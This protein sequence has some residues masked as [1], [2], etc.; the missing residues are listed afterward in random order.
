M[1]RVSLWWCVVSV[2]YKVR[3]KGQ[4]RRFSLTSLT[5][6]TQTLYTLYA[7]HEPTISLTLTRTRVAVCRVEQVPV[8]LGM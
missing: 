6:L 3:V 8:L 4:S 7:L 1:L 5:S 2:M